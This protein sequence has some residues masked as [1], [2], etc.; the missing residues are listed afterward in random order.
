MCLVTYMIRLIPLLIFR[1]KIENRFLQSFLYYIPY[2]VLSS[3]TIPAIFDS[4]SSLPSA[5]AGMITAVIL[6]LKKVDLLPVA[7]ASCTVVFI[8]ERLL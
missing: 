5:A 8:A 1:K 7:I 4:T 2:A 3:M 6:S